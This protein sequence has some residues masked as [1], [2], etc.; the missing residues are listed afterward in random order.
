M[1][2]KEPPQRVANP[3]GNSITTQPAPESIETEEGTAR[4]IPAGPNAFYPRPHAN[5]KPAQFPRHRPRECF[6]RARLSVVPLADSFNG[7]FS[8]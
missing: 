6:E 7:G 5:V 3:C 2:M 1:D 4:P 8:H